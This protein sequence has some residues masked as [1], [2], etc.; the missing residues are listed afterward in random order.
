MRAARS[1][2]SCSSRRSARRTT[3]SRPGTSATSSAPRGSCFAP[4]RASSRC[5]PSA[6]RCSRS[7]CGRLPDKWHGIADTEL[8]Y[9]RRYVDLIMNEDSRRVFEMRSAH[10]AL[11]ARLSRFAR[12]S[13]GGNADAASHSGRRGGAPLQDA[14]QRARRRHVSADR[15][16]ALLEAPHGRRLRARVRDQPQLP[17]RG[18]VDAAQ[19]R[20]HD[21]RAVSGVRRL[22]AISWR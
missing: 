13:R 19:S 20:I 18:R 1:R 17:Q 14:S 21:A 6:S 15:S 4:R 2:S 5:A 3:S 12:F 22:H 7:R 11:P 10:R 8:R 16:G 9:R